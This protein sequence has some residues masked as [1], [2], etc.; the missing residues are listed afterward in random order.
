VSDFGDDFQRQ[1]KGSSLWQYYAR[2]FTK[3]YLNF[4]GRA[5]RKEYWGFQLFN[6][7]FLFSTILLVV[8]LIGPEESRA[9][10]SSASKFL[11]VVPVLISLYFLVAFLPSLAVT[12]RR[13]HDVGVTGWL[14]LIN[15]IPYLGG[16]ILFILTVLTGTKG[17]NSYGPSPKTSGDDLATV[18]S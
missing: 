14:V 12:V 4:Q 17:P 3:N 13:L 18:F 1:N 11:Y 15:F 8:M 2:C 10:S 9:Q 16:L 6:G 7:L 5:R